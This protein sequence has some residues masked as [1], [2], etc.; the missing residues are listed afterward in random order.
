LTIH[1]VPSLYSVI[2]A[3]LTRSLCFRVYIRC[4]WPPTKYGTRWL[5]FTKL[6]VNSKLQR[7]QS[8]LLR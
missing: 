4:V 6:A 5:V 1:L 8:L 2:T 3:C 7:M